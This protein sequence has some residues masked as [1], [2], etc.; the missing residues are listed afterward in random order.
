MLTAYDTPTA[1]LLDEA[2]VDIIL[3]G[4]S[5]GTVLLGYRSTRQVLMDEMIHHAKAVRRGVARALL[6]GDV[7]FQGE[8][9]N[10]MRLYRET[11]RFVRA[12]QLDGVKI[13]WCP[14]IQG[15]IA[16]LVK[17][18]VSVMGHVGLTPQY[19]PRL[20]GLRV[21]G[22]E[23]GKALEI[24]NAAKKFEACGA[25]A[26]VLE[27]VPQELA[28]SITHALKIPTIGIGAGPNCDGQVLV[29]QDL[30][31]LS[32]N[33]RAKFVK[34]YANLYERERK[35]TSRFIRDVRSKRFPR[36]SQSF[37][38]KPNEFAKFQSLSRQASVLT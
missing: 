24:L 34:N 29:F 36:H 8:R 33:F 15:T 30:V 1:R 18:G 38:M 12:A 14:G 6:I 35:A 25:F 13:E 2:G 26:V 28:R 32:P 7:P 21:Q 9:V 19:A 5:V 22:K 16:R 3:I 4:D 11:K 37:K 27:C 17:S 31:G 20:G 23:A 10:P